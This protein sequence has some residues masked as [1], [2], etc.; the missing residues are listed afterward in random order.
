MVGILVL[1]C[2][3]HVLSYPRHTDSWRW[4]LGY[5]DLSAQLFP[6]RCSNAASSIALTNSVFNQ[7]LPSCITPTLRVNRQPTLTYSRACI[8]R[9]II[10]FALICYEGQ[11][12]WLPLM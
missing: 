1:V 8:V 11:S 6:E 4:P 12:S 5:I 3:A 7:T 2:T 10:V 9:S